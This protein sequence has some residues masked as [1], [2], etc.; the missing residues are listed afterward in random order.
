MPPFVR[1]QSTLNVGSLAPR[2]SADFPLHLEATAI[3]VDRIAH[4]PL[5]FAGKCQDVQGTVVEFPATSHPGNLSKKLYL[6]SLQNK[7]SPSGGAAPLR[8]QPSAVAAPA[9][10]QAA[11][12]DFLF[13][14]GNQ[15]PVAPGSAAVDSAGNLYVADSEINGIQVYDSSGNF[16]RGWGGYGTPFN[17]LTGVAVDSAGN[18]YVADSGNCRIQ[19]FDSSGKFLRTWGSYGVDNDQFDGLTGIAVDNAGNVYAAD[20]F[21]VRV[22]V[23]DSAGNYLRTIGSAGSGNGQFSDPK[24]WQ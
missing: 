22:Q 3:G 16:V 24:G 8:Y 11:P 12:G 9:S 20:R 19:V 18:V 1:V 7:P 5:F 14:W 10:A 2:Q 17:R 4:K 6:Q 21:A 15:H 13:K 23:F